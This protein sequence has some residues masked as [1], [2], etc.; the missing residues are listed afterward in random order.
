MD[1][2]TF[3]P[4]LN[5]AIRKDDKLILES[6]AKN[7]RFEMPL[8][9]S[10]CT[11][12]LGRKKLGTLDAVGDVTDK[13]RGRKYQGNLVIDREEVPFVVISYVGRDSGRRCNQLIADDQ[14][15]I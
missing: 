11:V 7:V 8:D 3:R 1:Y 13:T 6:N 14:D 4:F 5:R 15:G 10:V 9:H 12:F 2:T